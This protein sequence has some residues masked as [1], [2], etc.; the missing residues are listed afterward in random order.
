M[1]INVRTAPTTIIYLPSEL[2][3]FVTFGDVFIEGRNGKLILPDGIFIKNNCLVISSLIRG[4]FRSN[5]FSMIKGL[6]FKHVK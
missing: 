4:G 1:I 5:A 3:A 2:N 6:K